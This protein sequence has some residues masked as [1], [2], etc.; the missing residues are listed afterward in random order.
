M[1]QIDA[2]MSN[3]KGGG[4][5]DGQTHISSFIRQTRLVYG[6]EAASQKHREQERELQLHTHL[7]P[8][9]TDV[10]LVYRKVEK[11]TSADT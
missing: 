5:E 2:D 8:R 1:K 11:H 9:K 3:R 10:V 4:Q 6:R 7:Q